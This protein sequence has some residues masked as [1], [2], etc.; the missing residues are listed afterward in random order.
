MTHPDDLGAS[1]IEINRALHEDI[2]K[3]IS[4]KMDLG[5]GKKGQTVW[6]IDFEH[7]ENN[8]F[9]LVDEF[10]VKG[11][12]NCRADLVVFVNGLPLVV[13]ECKI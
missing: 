5:Q 12:E 6:F 8:D 7:P 9:L 4:V 2:I 13:I 1:L 11:Q 10:K 3:G